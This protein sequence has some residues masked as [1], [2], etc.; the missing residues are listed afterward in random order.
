MD[1][2]EKIERRCEAN[3]GIMRMYTLEHALNVM[4]CWEIITPD[5]YAN[6]H[7]RIGKK[8]C[9]LEAERSG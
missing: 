3:E 1:E 4:V 8:I 9:E 2:V 6:I 5:E 7:Q